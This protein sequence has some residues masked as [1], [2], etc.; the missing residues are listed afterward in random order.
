MVTVSHIVNKLVDEK[1][2]LQGAIGKGIKKRSSTLRNSCSAQKIR[3]K[4]NVRFRDIRFDANNLEV[5]Y[6][7]KNL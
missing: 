7:S 4:M 5:F 1:V 6:N 3:R 2:Y